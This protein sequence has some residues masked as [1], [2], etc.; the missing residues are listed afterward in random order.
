MSEMT[1][2]E[3]IAWFAQ[4]YSPIVGHKIDFVRTASGREIRFD[5]MTD[6]EAEFVASQFMLMMV[7][8][9]GNA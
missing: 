4:E 1:A 9:E 5:N 6:D 2:R 8:A 3:F 7:P